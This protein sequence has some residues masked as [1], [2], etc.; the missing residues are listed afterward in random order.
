M[1]Q[2]LI[3]PAELTIKDKK[4]V[5]KG[6]I[7][8]LAVYAR[9]KVV[10]VLTGE[11][12]CYY[13]V[14]YKNHMVYG[15]QL[16]QAPSGT[17]I[18]KAFQEGISIVSPH[19]LLS[20]GIPHLSVAI[21]NKNKVF[22]QIQTDFTLQESAYI[23]ATLDAFFE[24]DQLA[25]FID[26]IFY[27]YR[28]SG[29]FFKSFQIVQLL[30]TFAPEIKSMKHLINSQEFIP[31]HHFYQSSNLPAI[32]SKDPLFAELSAF[33]N[34]TQPDS[35]TF[36]ANLAAEHDGWT[37]LW[38][39]LEKSEQL[40]DSAAMEKYTEIALQLVTKE[41]WLLI[42]SMAGINPFRVLADSKAIIEKMVQKGNAEWAAL[43]LFDHMEELPDTYMP[44]LQTIWEKAETNFIISHLDRF[45]G[46]L[47][48]LPQSETFQEFEQK[49][50]Q[51]AVT[52]LN[53][54][55]L[56]TVCDKLS[57]FRKI[58]PD[59]KVLRKMNMM[60]GLLEDPDRMMEL[61]DC[62]AEFRQFD[63]AIDCFFWEMEL[64]PKNPSPVQKISKMY[65]YKGMAKEA[66]AYQK[67]FAQL[68]SNQAAG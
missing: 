61:G 29:K 47:S 9:S 1:N 15:A 57:V 23:A 36:L 27:H 51:L 32:M 14:Y 39:W 28:R 64:D 59:S 60:Q 63:K 26:K 30:N 54:Y 56:D 12:A 5:V 40:P 2:E 20:A 65:Q 53:Q 34:R 42:L 49:A 33:K 22:S 41:E 37:V 48:L 8:R 25:A 3:K 21:P 16:E 11:K 66:A 10:E 35:W 6:T 68:K 43:Y 31:Y 13:L 50:F 7:T 46:L 45:I 52:L 18:S 44:I 19:P 62:F 4:K 55:E 17:F 24:K 38:L 58:Y 67:V